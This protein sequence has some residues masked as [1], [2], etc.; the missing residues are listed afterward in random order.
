LWIGK[1]ARS[2]IYQTTKREKEKE[3]LAGE[4]LP[5]VRLMIHYNPRRNPQQKEGVLRLAYL[6]QSER[7]TGSLTEVGD[8]K[9]KEESLTKGWGREIH[10]FFG[11]HLRARLIKRT[12]E[13]VVPVG[14]REP[15]K[16]NKVQQQS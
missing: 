10:E 14:K 6:Q 8:K 1:G 13:K 7:C 9:R 15:K 4:R 2:K 12:D 11:G 3:T 5:N 16:D